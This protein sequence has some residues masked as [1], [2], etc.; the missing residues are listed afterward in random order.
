MSEILATKSR[1]PNNKYVN[2]PKMGCSCCRGGVLCR[3]RT[4][5]ANNRDNRR[6]AKQ[7]M[8]KLDVVE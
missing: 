3:N 7:A 2:D 1:K 6:K 8:R 4:K 5:R